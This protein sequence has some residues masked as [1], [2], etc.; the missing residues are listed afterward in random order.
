M[1]ERFLESLLRGSGA[2]VYFVY[3]VGGGVEVA[4]HS[5]SWG[6][7][8]QPQMLGGLQDLSCPQSCLSCR[9]GYHLHVGQGCGSWPA[10]PVGQLCSIVPSTGVH[11]CQVPLLRLHHSIGSAEPS[12]D[13]KEDSGGSTPKGFQK[14]LESRTYLQKGCS[15]MEMSRQFDTEAPPAVEM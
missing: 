4:S 9:P 6:G 15:G 10:S 2:G 1:L 3:F 8:L 11:A 13:G 14:G 5:P 12:C 7:I